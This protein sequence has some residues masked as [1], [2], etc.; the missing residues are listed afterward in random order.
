MFNTYIFCDWNA[1]N[2]L[3]PAQPAADNV[4]V[5]EATPQDGL[6]NEE[7][8]TGRHLA[9]EH[10][11]ERLLHHVDLGHRILIGF[12]FAYGYPRGLAAALNLPHDS[13]TWWAIWTELCIRVHDSPQ[14]DS[15][16]FSAASDLNHIAG[17][18][19]AGPFWGVPPNQATAYLLPNGPGFPFAA[20][21]DIELIRLRITEERLRGVQEAWKL[22]GA[23][24]VGSQTLVGIP[25]VWRLRRHPKLARLS[26]VWPFET[27]F[28]PTPC[29]D[30]T[31]CILHAEIWPGVMDNEVDQILADDEDAIRDQ[32]QVRVMC[33]WA[34]DRDEDGSLGRYFNTPSNLKRNQLDA[35][36]SHEGWILG[37]P[38]DE[39]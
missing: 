25:Y 10:V 6:L 19:G 24:S 5:G 3:G 37:S 26:R 28:T 22:Y 18:G 4:W 12:D 29:S 36:V 7:Y 21:N 13:L 32:I 9:V 2:A 38:N 35:C 27:S 11:T 31:P 20:Q 14:N 1:R 8:F 23:G 34:S 33:Q 16:R 30:L 39:A 17:L 15:N